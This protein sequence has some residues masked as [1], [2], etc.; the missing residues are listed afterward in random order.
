[1]LIRPR[2]VRIQVHPLVADMRLKKQ[3]VP[4]HRRNQGAAGQKVR[5]FSAAGT[6]PLGTAEIRNISRR[7]L[8]E[9]TAESIP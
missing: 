7:S 8:A 3:Q 6:V 4:L 1:M 5:G 2:A 9:F